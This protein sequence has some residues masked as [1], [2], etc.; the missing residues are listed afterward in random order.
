LFRH[1]SSL[2]LSSFIPLSLHTCF[3]IVHSRR[4]DIVNKASPASPQLTARTGQSA[5]LVQCTHCIRT[6]DTRATV[7][8]SR[9]RCMISFQERRRYHVHLFT[10]TLSS[11]R[12]DYIRIFVYFFS[13][14]KQAMS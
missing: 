6:L 10:M 12:M 3:T 11:P 2:F 7:H 14:G 8:T 4:R 9:D 1:W 13:Q 5:Q